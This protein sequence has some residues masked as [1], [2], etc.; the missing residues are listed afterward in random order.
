MLP[1]I[2]YT[3][4][5][6][7]WAC[8]HESISSNRSIWA[9][10]MFTENI[11]G[12][13]FV[14]SFPIFPSYFI[15]FHFILF[16]LSTFS[17]SLFP[18]FLP[19]LFP[20]T[21][22][23]STFL[24]FHSPFLFHRLCHHLEAS[25]RSPDDHDETRFEEMQD[26]ECEHH[27]SSDRHEDWLTQTRI[28]RRYMYISSI[29]DLLHEK[30]NHRKNTRTCEKYRCPHQ[31]NSRTNILLRTHIEEEEECWRRTREA[32]DE[33]DEEVGLEAHEEGENLTEWREPYIILL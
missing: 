3:V 9:I 1:K 33:E 24:L 10:I 4:S 28:H 32:D 17:L 20:S 18:F 5:I 29:V 25:H 13:F 16:Y 11:P 6:R 30:N 31:D 27:H 23:F 14:L 21:L 26:I 2:W 15:P 8:F 7:S 12:I 22:Y 19:T